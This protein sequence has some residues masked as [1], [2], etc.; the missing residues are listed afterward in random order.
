MVRF[1]AKQRSVRWIFACICWLLIGA[2][3]HAAFLP[4]SFDL[5][6]SFPKA[7][8]QG[9]QGSAVGWAI[10]YTRAYYVNVLEHRD[11]SKPENVP[12][13]AYIYNLAK[14]AGDCDAGMSIVSALNVLR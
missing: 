1:A 10:A 2:T 12:S 5:S 11:V 7:G 8:N 3:S 6:R 9:A 13:P 4:E 14:A